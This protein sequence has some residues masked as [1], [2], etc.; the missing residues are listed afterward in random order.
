VAHVTSQPEPPIVELKPSDGIRWA[1][2]GPTTLRASTWRFWGNKKGDFYLSVRH[3][4]G[5]LKTSLHRD[6]HC[7]TG[8]TSEYASNLPTKRPRHLDRWALPDLPIVKAIQVLTPTEELE[9][10]S[11]EETVPMR[12]LPIPEPPLMSVVT[13]FILGPDYL[14]PTDE[15]WPGAKYGAQPIGVAAAPS[16]TAFLVYSQQPMSD[17]TRLEI[18]AYRRRLLADA[19]SLVTPSPGLRAILIGGNDPG[20]RYLV[21]IAYRPENPNLPLQPGA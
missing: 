18:E 17:T 7:H 16:R 5:V 4:G 10:Y 13:V 9:A 20:P 15:P 11:S 6:G 21:E 19:A 2:G 1:L 3:L 14:T 12:W 8:F